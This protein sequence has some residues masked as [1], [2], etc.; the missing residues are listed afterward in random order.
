MNRKI[1]ILAP[2]GS[3]ITYRIRDVE[4]KENERTRLETDMRSEN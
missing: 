2:A 4:L 1:E 3:E